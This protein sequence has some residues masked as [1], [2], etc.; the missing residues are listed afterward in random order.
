M[1][2][3]GRDQTRTRLDYKRLRST[4]SSSGLQK[5]ND[6]LYQ[7]V[8]DLIDGSG[9]FKDQLLRAF[10][11]EHDK[12]DLTSQVDRVLPPENGGSYSSYYFP[13][14][15]PAANVTTSSVFYT[16]YFRAGKMI[17]V[18]GKVSITPTLGATITEF[19]I[20][21]PIP[22]NFSSS[23]QLNGTCIG[24]TDTGIPTIMSS[25]II[26]GNVGLQTANVKMF[27]L[28]AGIHDTRFIF[29][30]ELF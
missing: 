13:V 19:E 26:T 29:A 5:E 7:V 8:G 11:K 21:L 22:S 9:D 27:S 18:S 30:Y 12:L 2:F 10:D 20:S 24:H 23:D 16:M 1:A 4:L 14:I 17:Y 25:G 15:T 6:A 3:K 28:D